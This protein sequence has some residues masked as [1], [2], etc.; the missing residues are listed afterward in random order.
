MRCIRPHPLELSLPMFVLQGE[1][2]TTEAVE[3]SSRQEVR[4]E[5]LRTFGR[6]L[7]MAMCRMKYDALHLLKRAQRVPS[8]ESGLRFERCLPLSMRVFPILMN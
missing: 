3:T 1:G 6:S 7:K 2:V 5:K 4:A 8:P